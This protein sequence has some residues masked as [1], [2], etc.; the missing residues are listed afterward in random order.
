MILAI[1]LLRW[2]KV[3][4]NHWNHWSNNK[5]AISLK[6]VCAIKSVHLQQL[7]FK[8]PPE[9]N[10]KTPPLPSV[11]IKKHT[12]AVEC[13][14]NRTEAKPT[15][16]KPSWSTKRQPTKP[17]ENNNYAKS[18]I[19]WPGCLFRMGGFRPFSTDQIKGKMSGSDTHTHS[20]LSLLNLDTKMDTRLKNKVEFTDIRRD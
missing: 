17:S 9:L 8:Y 5:H 18:F 2:T 1:W 7:K 10:F 15:N 3:K 19:F 11:M 20:Y 16:N 4:R 6:L 14:H 13:H 12:G